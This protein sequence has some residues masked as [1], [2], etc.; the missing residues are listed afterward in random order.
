MKVSVLPSTRV[1]LPTERRPR[2][3]LASPGGGAGST[4]GLST[5]LETATTTI[6]LDRPFAVKDQAGTVAGPLLVATSAVVKAAP[7]IVS[8]HFDADIGRCLQLSYVVPTA[9]VS[10]GWASR[11][12]A[13][14]FDPSP[15]SGDAT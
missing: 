3:T 8:V 7:V 2:S 6:G 9:S 14:R 12:L 1:S 4:R 10:A 13:E 11:T 15:K 5:A